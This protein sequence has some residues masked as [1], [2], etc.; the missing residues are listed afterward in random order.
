MGG[1]CGASPL[2]PEDDR[3]AVIIGKTAIVGIYAGGDTVVLSAAASE[4]MLTCD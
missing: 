4:G 2:T 1:E 3:I